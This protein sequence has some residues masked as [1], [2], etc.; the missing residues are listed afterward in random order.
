MQA[1][2]IPLAARYMAH[3][4]QSTPAPSAEAAD[5]PLLKQWT[6]AFGVPPFGSI[7]PEDFRPAFERAFAA[8]ATEVAAIAADPASAA[9]IRARCRARWLGSHR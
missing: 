5:N 3:M 8:H 6:G 4:N 9:R 7:K 2:A 1:D